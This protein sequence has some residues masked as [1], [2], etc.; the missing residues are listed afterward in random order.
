MFCGAS[1]DFIMDKSEVVLKSDAFTRMSKFGLQTV[2]KLE[3][4]SASECEVYVG[5][6]R[7]AAQRCWDAGKL[8]TDEHIR[9]ELGEGLIGL[10]RFITMT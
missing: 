3:T 1:L 5:C 10:I 9:Q 7:C 2:L 8:E 4:L 6:K